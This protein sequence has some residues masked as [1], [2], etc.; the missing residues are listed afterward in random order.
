MERKPIIETD[1]FVTIPSIN[2]DAIYDFKCFDGHAI[3]ERVCDTENA[4]K[5]IRMKYPKLDEVLED[6][7]KSSYVLEYRGLYDLTPAD[8]HYGDIMMAYGE[9]VE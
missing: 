9:V 4:P 1:I 8:I 5:T 2:D 3:G 6:E 7:N